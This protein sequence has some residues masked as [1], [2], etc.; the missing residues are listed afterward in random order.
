MARLR[1]SEGASIAGAADVP[2]DL[3]DPHAPVWASNR[4]AARW[5]TTH[6]L[7]AAVPAAGGRLRHAAA[8]TA[9]CL[10]EGIDPKR[11]QEITGWSAR[12][13]AME[14]AAASKGVDYVQPRRATGEC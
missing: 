6:D 5:H 9:W 14:R 10:S 7:P 1:D 13:T 2:A 8:L 11:A 4:S 3:L 12:P